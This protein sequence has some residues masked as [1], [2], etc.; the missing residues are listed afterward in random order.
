MRLTFQLTALANEPHKTLKPSL[1]LVHTSL[2]QGNAAQ[3]YNENIFGRKLTP[4]DGTSPQPH[5][6]PHFS[7]NTAGLAPSRFSAFNPVM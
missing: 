3:A 5:H 7:G 4:A 2:T 1:I 6:E